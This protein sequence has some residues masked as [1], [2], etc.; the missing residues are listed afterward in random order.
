M[1]KPPR[2]E[3]T[4]RWYHRYVV[5]EVH[6]QRGVR[7]ISYHVTSFGAESGAIAL[8]QDQQVRWIDN[9]EV[10]PN[11]QRLAPKAWKPC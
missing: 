9:A 5:T 10:W 2:T 6:S 7:T 8:A 3:P 11:V 4:R 1:E